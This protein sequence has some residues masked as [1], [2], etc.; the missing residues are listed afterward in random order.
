MNL[1]WISCYWDA[2]ILVLMP[3]APYKKLYKRTYTH[4]ISSPIHHS[5][6]PKTMLKSSVS[7]K[8][9]LSKITE[10]HKFRINKSLC[11]KIEDTGRSTLQVYIKAGLVINA[12]ALRVRS[13]ISWLSTLLLFCAWL[14]NLKIFSDPNQAWMHLECSLEAIGCWAIMA[15]LHV[16][17]PLKKASV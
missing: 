8:V 6:L 12:I 3:S 10:M 1:I 14:N 15:K 2:K 5:H 11:N 7:Y 16:T 9:W 17:K 13:E 4:I